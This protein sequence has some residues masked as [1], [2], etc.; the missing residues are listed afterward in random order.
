VARTLNPVSRAVRRD[1]ILD[2]AERIIRSDGYEHMSI[3]D[4][5]DELGVSR[6]AIY[7]YFDSKEA[8]L[9][10]VIARMADAAFAMLDP[11]VADATLPA[12]LKLQAVFATGG[13]WKAQRSD[14]L[15]SL[16]RSWYSDRN[17]LARLRLARATESRFT[18]LLARI[19]RQGADEGAFTPAWP[20]QTATV[21]AATLIASGDAIGRLVLDRQDGLV[22]FEEA[23]RLVGAY[24]ESIERILGLPE[25]T[26]VL[27]DPVAMH[28]WFA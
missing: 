5:Q 27:V 14:I 6:G 18:P 16:A 3:Q 21:L 28:V 4:V 9:E 7:H 17:D 26:F 12:S 15:L 8:L 1:A 20:E 25:G 24:A 22:P 23:E 13:R 10:A 11:V 19:V 2:V